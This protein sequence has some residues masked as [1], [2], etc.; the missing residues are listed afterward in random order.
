MRGNMERS[1][2]KFSTEGFE[3]FPSG[4]SLMLGHPQEYTVK[5]Y[6]ILSV[7]VQ[8]PTKV[9]VNGDVFTILPETG[10]LNH[11]EYNSPVYEFSVQEDNKPIYFKG[12]W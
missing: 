7:M 4:Q 5:F 8:Q 6:R 1:S 10:F 9:K 11:P 3:I 12:E 2:R